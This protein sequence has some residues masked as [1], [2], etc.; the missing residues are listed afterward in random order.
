MHF[1]YVEIKIKADSEAELIV[2]FTSSINTK[3]IDVDHSDEGFFPVCQFFSYFG[4]AVGIYRK[5]LVDK[6]KIVYSPSL[7]QQ[8]TVLSLETKPLPA[9]HMKM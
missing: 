3:L 5:N 6:A 9:I 2:S 1:L 4:V 7:P 8:H